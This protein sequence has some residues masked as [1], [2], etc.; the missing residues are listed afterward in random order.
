[1]VCQP[2]LSLYF[3]CFNTCLLIFE[4][5]CIAVVGVPLHSKI[6]ESKR[7]N[8]NNKVKALKVRKK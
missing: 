1:M 2:C 4:Y 8:K 3:L 5:C 7:K 6:K